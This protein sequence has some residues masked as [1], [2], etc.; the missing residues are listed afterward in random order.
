MDQTIVNPRNGVKMSKKK[1]HSK[2]T[3][4]GCGSDK[5]GT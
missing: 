4:C 1:W 3:V 5:E 2:Q